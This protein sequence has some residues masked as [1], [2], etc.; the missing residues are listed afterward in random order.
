[1]NPE[2]LPPFDRSE[3]NGFRCMRSTTAIPEGALAERKLSPVNRMA[4]PPMSEAVF[5]AYAAGFAYDRSDPQG[6]VEAVENSEQWRKEKVSFSAAYGNERVTAYLFLPKNA[7]P[8][9]QT[10]LYVPGFEA[11]ELRSSGSLDVPDFLLQSGRA[12][13]YPIYKGTYERGGGRPPKPGMR[14]ER[15]L[16]IQWAKDISRSIDYLETRSD[17]DIKRLAYYSVSYGTFYGPV[18]TQVEHRFKTSV[19]TAGGL[20]PIIPLPEVEPVYYLPRN[21]T[22]VLLIAGRTDY[23]CPIETHQKPLIR[24][25]AAAPQDK[26]HV[27]LNCGHGLHPLQDVIKEVIPWLDRYLGP[28]STSG[29]S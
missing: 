27:I 28:V 5:R 3:V 24:L 23:I 1:M 7:K 13:I 15:D 25:S 18:F 17:I 6:A 9:F 4:V 8:P 14:E 20:S 22:P 19:L 29:G 21:R 12:V 26:R 10:V 11:V 16:L 2:N